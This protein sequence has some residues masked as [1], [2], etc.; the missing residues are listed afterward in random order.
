MTGAARGRR[1]ALVFNP[2][3]GQGR[4]ARRFAAVVEALR[5]AFAL[6]IVPSESAD[7]LRSA[8]RA[9]AA[10]GLDALFV[11]GGDGTLR[12][13]ARELLG[14]ATALGAL[15]GGTTNVVACAALGL[16][17][18]PLGAARALVEA[19]ARALD[20]G[21]AGAGAFLMQLSGG[22]DARVMAVLSP[23]AKRR[24]GKLAIAATGLGELL[25]Y[26]FEEF[27]LEV[28]G[29]PRRARGFVVA[30]LAQY[31]G[32]FEIVPG[33]RA[34][35]GALDLLLFHGRS[36]RAAIGFALALARGRHAR[37]A[38]VET[39]RCGRV[40]VTGPARAPLQADG[41]P[42]DAAL[43]LEIRLAPERLL[44]LAPAPA[45]GGAA[46]AAR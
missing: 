38:D 19:E 35:D 32:R 14:S 16:P 46:P 45:R 2:T 4:G 20:V 7:A 44:V 29:A 33:A 39:A 10:R 22:L 41:D 36:R 30:N 9:A 23:R 31:A 17:R 25:R 28:D 3:A 8:A 26:R 15:P 24:F 18:D 6:E 43:P 5:S 40:V 11:L 27:A 21:L 1:A 13:A 37:R 42:L 12:L 34:D